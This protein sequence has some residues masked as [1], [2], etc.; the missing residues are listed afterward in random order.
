[1]K[2]GYS[3][4]HR[5]YSQILSD[6][7]RLQYDILGRITCDDFDGLLDQIILKGKWEEVLVGTMEVVL[8]KND[9]SFFTRI[10]DYTRRDMEIVEL[11]KN[12]MRIIANNIKKAARAKTIL[13]NFST[14]QSRNERT[15]EWKGTL[16]DKAG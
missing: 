5:N 2:Y 15:K 11:L 4:D 6:L 12:K 3:A 9:N 10:Y 8:T 13:K 16:L 14:P 1:M 7:E